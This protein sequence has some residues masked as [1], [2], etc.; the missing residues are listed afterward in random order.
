MHTEFPEDR[1]SQPRHR[2]STGCTTRPARELERRLVPQAMRLVV[3]FAWVFTLPALRIAHAQDGAV[4]QGDE[5]DVTAETPGEIGASVRPD[6]ETSRDIALQPVLEVRFTARIDGRLAEAKCDGDTDFESSSQGRALTTLSGPKMTTAPVLN[7][8]TGGLLGPSGIARFAESHDARAMMTLFETLKI[9]ALV[10]GVAE[11]GIWRTDLPDALRALHTAGMPILAT[12]LRCEGSAKHLCQHVRDSSDGPLFVERDGL[13]IAVMS[14]MPEAALH[15]VAHQH[16]DGV[17]VVPPQEAIAAAVRKAR[18]E[19]ADLTIAVIDASASVNAAGEALSLAEALPE[20]DRP[21]LIIASRAGRQL[22]FARPPFVTPAVV[23]AQPGTATRALL[24]APVGG[25]S[26]LTTEA[27]GPRPYRLDI[28]ASP[29][30]V[31][32]AGAPLHGAYETWL[33]KTGKAFCDQWGK[34]LPGG[35]LSRPFTAEDLLSVLADTTREVGNAE[36][37]V[38][39][40]NLVDAAF[41]PMRAGLLSHGDV[42]LGVRYDEP[43]VSAD[44]SDKWLRNLFDRLANYHL[45]A[46]GLTKDGDTYK[47]HGRPL[48]A[49]GKYRVSTIQF[50]ASGGDDALPEGEVEWTVGHATVRDAVLASLSAPSRLDPRDRASNS[51][52]SWEWVTRT[53]GDITYSDTSIHA[54]SDDAGDPIYDSSQLTRANNTSVGGYAVVQVNAQNPWLGVE[55]ELSARYRDTKTDDGPFT[56]SDDLITLRST[57]VYRGWIRE[58]DAFYV[59]QP[60]AALYGES[61]FTVPDTRD[62]RRVLVRPTGGLRF[63]LLSH[64][65]LQLSGGAEWEG[66][67]RDAEVRPGAGALLTLTPYK[68]IE[69]GTRTVELEGSVDYF[70]TATHRTLRMS[71]DLRVALGGPFSLVFGSRVYGED[72]PSARAAYATDF[73][74][75]LRV[76]WLGRTTLF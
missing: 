15:T 56:E 37:A 3:L 47:L 27:H 52:E 10:F 61:E 35:A 63:A 36:V 46:P 59:P 66:L 53:S 64:V 17:T 28:L 42:M 68:L 33:K 72:R 29:M 14:A 23:A 20:H 2:R 34:A 40:R 74:A 57:T 69:A 8:D 31:P 44:V 71:A 60:Y 24:R 25:H 67:D 50:L 45:V 6:E 62:Y 58:N 13:R 16:A 75:A 7:L 21:D 32:D 5:S 51:T 39:N 76:A 26:T 12:N 73:T 9:D 54:P 30:P 18:L 38:L 65:N 1:I 48:V 43:I 4:A 41:H 22:I 19:Q 55:N 49:G 11:L 70:F